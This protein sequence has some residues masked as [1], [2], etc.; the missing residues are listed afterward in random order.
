MNNNKP[1]I[2]PKNALKLPLGKKRISYTK[3]IAFS[4]IMC[5]F[6]VAVMSIG[7]F[8]DTLDITMAC[9]CS[10]IVA[11]CMIELGGNIP[12][13]VYASTSVL[14]FLLLPNKSVSLIYI[15]FF[16]FYPIFKRTAEKL[17]RLI[18]WILKFALFNVLI[19]I[20]Y[21]AAVKLFHI[22]LES[23]KIYVVLLLNIIFF[24][25]D[26]AL[27]LFVTAYVL[28]FRKILRINKFFK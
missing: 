27:S 17:P 16:G 25:L 15:L 22:E 2:N 14:S 5:A 23:I 4:S 9:I 24:S 26:I 10:F 28:R 18:G 3:K 6:G 19:A 11:V 7:S 21:V 1:P 8:I 20:Y 12:L 13:L